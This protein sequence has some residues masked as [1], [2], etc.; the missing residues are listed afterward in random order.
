[1]D[2]AAKKPYALFACTAPQRTSALTTKRLPR[3]LILGLPVTASMKEILYVDAGGVCDQLRNHWCPQG[4]DSTSRQHKSDNY[5]CTCNEALGFEDIDD[6]G[7]NCIP[8]NGS[9]YVNYLVLSS[10][11]SLVPRHKATGLK[12]FSPLGMPAD[13]AI[14]FACVNFFLFL[15]IA[16]SPIISGST[17]PIFAIFLPNDRYLFLPRDAM[18][19][20]VYAVVV[21]LCVCVCV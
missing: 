12:Y 3:G 10:L 8:E 2:T 13:R 17:G 18:L 9:K 5:S 11:I 6:S 21:C 15:M 7:R 4:C 14:Y 20:A 16:W 1:L 19:S